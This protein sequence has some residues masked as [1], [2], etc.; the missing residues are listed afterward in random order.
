M[1]RGSSSLKRKTP[2]KRTKPLQNKPGTGLSKSTA[3]LQRKTPLLTTP[4]RGQ[5][6]YS[7]QKPRKPLRSTPPK[8]TS[9]ERLTRK[10]VEERS[11]GFCE[12]CG[13]PGATDKAH[14]ISRGV[15]GGGEPAN[16]L[17]LCRDC[18]QYHHLNPNI[19]Y[20]G[21]WHLRSTSTPTE[22]PV[23]FHHDGTF[24]MAYLHNDGTFTWAE[25]TEEIA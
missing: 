6:A 4:G 21:G 24:G 16:I 20:Q 22:C 9:E 14:R 17:D 12:K 5:D 19:A 23:R 3:P 11:D 2:L 18:H 13:I 10:L 8:V 7:D 15:G 25:E 1:N